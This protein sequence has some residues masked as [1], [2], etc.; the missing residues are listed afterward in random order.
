MPQLAGDAERLLLDTGPFM[1]FAEAQQ[2]TALLTWLGGGAHGMMV[3]QVFNELWGLSND[4]PGLAPW[5]E[6]AVARPPVLSLDAG[7]AG[8]VADVRNAL[9]KAG[10]PPKKHLGEAATIVAALHNEGALVVMDDAD[11][12]S[13]ARAQGLMVISTA[14]LSAELAARRC[15][16][17]KWS[18]SEVR[19][20]IGRRVRR[21]GSGCRSW[22]AACRGR[23]A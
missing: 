14:Q 8:E 5:K 10:D 23:R 7:L 17:P 12:K 4:H 21:R 9:R 18:G 20:R 15:L 6:A 16:V 11:G 13:Y 3:Q 1:R 19:A 22:R 2:L